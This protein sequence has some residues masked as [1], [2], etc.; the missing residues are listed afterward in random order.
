MMAFRIVSGYW[1]S[2]MKH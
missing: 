2:H 1:L